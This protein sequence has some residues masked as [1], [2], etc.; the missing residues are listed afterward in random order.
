LIQLII[1]LVILIPILAMLLDS[2]IGKALASRL[3]DR[4]LDAGD[5]IVTERVGYL[6]GEVDRLSTELMRLD[7]QGQFLQKLLSERPSA[8]ATALPSGDDPA[9]P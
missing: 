2:D 3:G 4:R 6:E 9:Q 5:D 1:I 8:D 7:E